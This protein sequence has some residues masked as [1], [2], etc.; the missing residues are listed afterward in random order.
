MVCECRISPV[1]VAMNGHLDGEVTRDLRSP[2]L[3]TTCWDDPPNG[4]PITEP[5]KGTLW[6]NFY[7]LNLKMEV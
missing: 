6:N 2:W 7:M 4:H 1:F 3:L 5:E